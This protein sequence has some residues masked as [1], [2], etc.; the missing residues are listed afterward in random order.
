MVSIFFIW[1][2]TKF[3]VKYDLN[4]AY[5]VLIK[6]FNDAIGQYSCQIL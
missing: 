4:F 6:N 3:T 5:H 1:N 2:L